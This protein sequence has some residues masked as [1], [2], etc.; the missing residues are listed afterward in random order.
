MA[1]RTPRDVLAKNF[2]VRQPSLQ[3]L[4]REELFIFQAPVPGPLAADQKAAAGT[5]PHLLIASLF[6]P[7]PQIDDKRSGRRG[8]HHRL[9]HLQGI[10]DRC[11]RDRDPSP[12]WNARGSL[13]S[14]CSARTMYFEAGDVGYLQQTL[15]HYI[16]TNGTE[17]SASETGSYF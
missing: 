9:N 16:E 8:P 12:G 17:I 4:R 3:T 10:H 15:A 7:G 11:S 14:S 5:L 13:A 6:E 2:G 1:A